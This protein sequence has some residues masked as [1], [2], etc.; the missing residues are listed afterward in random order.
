[1][2][3]LQGY[4]S[5]VVTI[6][7]EQTTIVRFSTVQ[8]RGSLMISAFQC[9]AGSNSAPAN[10][11]TVCVS[12]F[13]PQT[14]T[15]SGP[16]GSNVTTSGNGV[17][18]VNYLSAGTYSLTGSTVCAVLTDSGANASTFSV[19]AG[20]TTI[21]RVFNCVPSDG[22]GGGQNGGVSG[23]GNG[24]GTGGGTGSPVGQPGG[25]S[26]GDGTNPDQYTAGVGGEGS[27]VDGTGGSAVLGIYASNSH[28]LVR[29]L[30]SAGSGSTAPSDFWW[31]ILLLT[32]AAGLALI[33]RRQQKLARQKVRTDR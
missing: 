26:D 32:G 16:S 29:G 3:G 33:G 23:P 21:V 11:A 13:G 14:L 9:P 28:L 25:G 5:T 30:P 4:A 18:T 12:P 8:T 15:L 22:T 2:T 10:P 27:D 31:P 20:Q 1:V 7:A 6:T 19:Q 24:D 17:A